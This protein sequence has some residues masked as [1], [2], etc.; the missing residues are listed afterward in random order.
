MESRWMLPVFAQEHT[1]ILTSICES[2]LFVA[3][4]NAMLKAHPLFSSTFSLSLCK[5]ITIKNW[6]ELH[7]N[8][9]LI[10]E[11]WKR[12]QEA[13]ERCMAPATK[14]QNIPGQMSSVTMSLCSP[15]S[16]VSA[17]VRSD[18]ATSLQWRDF[19]EI[20]FL[21]SQICFSKRLSTTGWWIR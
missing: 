12:G 20:L 9:W 15:F 13:A 2:L 21:L 18:F 4:L 19:K 11:E 8:F 16:I 6:I 1:R 17:Y 3:E 5:L 7:T 10:V 14:C